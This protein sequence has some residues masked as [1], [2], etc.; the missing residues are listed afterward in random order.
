MNQES[1]L[2]IP[3]QGYSDPSGPIIIGACEVN[4][5]EK[6]VCLR[7][8]TLMSP[9]NQRRRYQEIFVIRNDDLAEFRVDLGPASDFKKNDIIVVCGGFL[10]VKNAEAF[11]YH[12]VGEC[13]E[14]AN[15]L[16]DCP[17]LDKKELAK[18]NNINY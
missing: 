11:I 3:K 18:V 14:M 13:M 6:G 7:E 1:K 17:A 10:D 16:R 5:D 4:K 9:K 8:L 2:I 12:T 15:Q